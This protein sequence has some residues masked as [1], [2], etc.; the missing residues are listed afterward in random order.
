MRTRQ[1][2]LA[3]AVS[4]SIATGALWGALADDQSKG[5]DQGQR[6]GD[7]KLVLKKTLGVGSDASGKPLK[8]G[9]F[10]ISF[11]D[12]KIELYILADRT[13]ASVD[14]FDSEEP[15]SSVVSARNVPR[16]I[17]HHISVSR[18]SCWSMAW[19]TIAFQVPTASSLW[20]TRR[21]GPETV[22]AGSR[23]L[24]SPRR[25]FITTIDH[26]RDRPG[27]TRWPTTRGTTFLPRQTMPILHPSSRCSIP[28]PRRSL[29]KIPFDKGTNT[30][31]PCQQRRGSNN[32]NGRRRQACSTSRF[33]FRTDPTGAA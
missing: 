17:L 7:E 5:D 6:R 29:G 31:P 1:V 27:L 15:N 28:K 32:H 14:L 11:V 30:R 10:D 18:A 23:S 9:A 19:R 4:L 8:L 22:T 33:R 24:I 21:S 12:P 3:S 26:G 16:A 20:I 2:L 13:N 25:Q